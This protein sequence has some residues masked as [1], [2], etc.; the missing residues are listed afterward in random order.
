MASSERNNKKRIEF[1]INF[2]QHVEPF[3]DKLIIQRDLLRTKERRRREVGRRGE[4]KEEK[5]TPY[6][7]REKAEAD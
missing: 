3:F 7:L 5:W 2:S 1:K 6:T 4:R